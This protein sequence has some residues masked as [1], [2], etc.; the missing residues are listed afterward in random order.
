MGKRSLGKR[1]ITPGQAVKILR[2]NGIEVT[3]GQAKIILDFL[4]VLAKLTVNQYFNE[5]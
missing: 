5:D 3:E 1:N 2:H 4:Y